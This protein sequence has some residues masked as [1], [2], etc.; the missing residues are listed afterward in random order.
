MPIDLIALKEKRIVKYICSCIE[1]FIYQSQCDIK[2]SYMS[3]SDDNEFP[4]NVDAINHLGFR[5]NFFSIQILSFLC[6]Y[7]NNL[8]RVV[9]TYYIDLV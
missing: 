2:W 8:F 9:K 1:Y 7:V 3:L 6:Q 5:L 4:E